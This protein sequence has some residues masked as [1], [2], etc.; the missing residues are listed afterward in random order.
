MTERTVQCA[1][2][3]EVLPALDKPP[4]PGP[5]GREIYERVSK[6]AW[7]DWMDQEVLVINHYVLNLVDSKHQDF[8]MKKM[9]EYLLEGAEGVDTSKPPEDR[10]PDL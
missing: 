7:Q 2:L 10:P 6:Q 8:L 1:R 5:L 3:G 4:L 9:R